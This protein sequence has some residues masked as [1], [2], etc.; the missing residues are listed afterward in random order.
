MASIDDK[1]EDFNIKKR[2]KKA[3]PVA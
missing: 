3:D 2:Y 1:E